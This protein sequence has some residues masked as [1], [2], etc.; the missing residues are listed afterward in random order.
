[1]N[2]L[3]DRKA[4]T[5]AAWLR[6]HPGAEVVCRDGSAAYAEAIRQGAP[7]AAQASDRWHLWHGL[8]GAV[9]KTVIAHS[10]SWRAAQSSPQPGPPRPID[11]RTRTRHAAVHELLDQGVGL[12]D[13][14]RRLGWALPTIRS[15]AT[16]GRHRRAAAAATALRPH[17]GRPLPR[18]PAPTARRRT[19][20]AGHPAIGGDP[21]AGYTGSANLL[22]RYLNQG[23]ARAERASPP[24]RRL[25]AWIMSRPAE[26]PDHEREHL[27]ELLAACP[28]LT[29]LAEHVRTFAD[30]LTT[31]PGADLENRMTAVEA[32]DLPAL[33][34]FVRGLRKDLA[35]RPALAREP[36]HGGTGDGGDMGPAPR[37]PARAAGRLVSRSRMRNWKRRPAPSRSMTRLRACW[38]SHSPVGW[39]VTPRM[40]TRRVACS[41]TNNA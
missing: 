22:V 13:C 6:E 41:M 25:V 27:D 35:A 14:A 39:A 8:A 9:E 15:S 36:G 37:R 12:L 31:R 5:L 29:V 2:V 23:R 19:R 16:P 38:V 32:S 3:P 40:W 33:H 28:Q 24:V 7:E 10:T 11:E 18:A 34:T 30:L 1:V 20:R 21:R 17:P 4:A 26:L